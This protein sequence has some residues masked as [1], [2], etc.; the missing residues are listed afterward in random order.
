MCR[1][2]SRSWSGLLDGERPPSDGLKKEGPEKE[3]NTNSKKTE[4]AVQSKA[5]GGGLTGQT[6]WTKWRSRTHQR[7]RIERGRDGGG[8][9]W[10]LGCGREPVGFYLSQAKTGGTRMAGHQKNCAIL[11][12]VAD[13]EINHSRRVGGEKGNE[14]FAVRERDKVASN[15]ARTPVG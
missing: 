10:G 6:S 11:F 5:L 4:K 14:T 9:D 1:Q 13:R 7:S 8:V 12:I 2:S 3:K 15:G